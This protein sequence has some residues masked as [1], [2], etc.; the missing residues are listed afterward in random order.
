MTSYTI[1]YLSCTVGIIWPVECIPYPLRYM[2]LALPQTYASEALRCIMYRGNIYVL[3]YSH[4]FY[5]KLPALAY[6]SHLWTHECTHACS[7]HAQH[8]QSSKSLISF[9]ILFISTS[10]NVRYSGFALVS[11]S[12]SYCWSRRLWK[13]RRGDRPSSLPPCYTI[14]TNHRKSEEL[15]PAENLIV[16]MQWKMRHMPKLAVSEFNLGN[17]LK[18]FFSKFAMYGAKFTH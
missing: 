13:I 11:Q 12:F 17:E 14:H 5:S 1:S 10:W 2:S 7:C 8:S 6:G 15:F 16:E 3:H 4:L 9:W 18:L